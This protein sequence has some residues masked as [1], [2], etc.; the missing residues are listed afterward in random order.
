[1][2]DRADANEEKLL[3]LALPLET[4]VGGTLRPDSDGD[5]PS[6]RKAP[7]TASAA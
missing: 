5:N 7:P 6:G 2:L 4:T 1:V 3:K